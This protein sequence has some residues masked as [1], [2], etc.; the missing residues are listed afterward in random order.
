MN[1]SKMNWLDCLWWQKL[2]SHW[3]K[4]EHGHIKK[5]DES[6]IVKKPSPITSLFTFNVNQPKV[7]FII[8]VRGQKDFVLIFDHMEDT[9]HKWVRDLILDWN[10]KEFVSDSWRPCCVLL[11]NKIHFFET[12][13]PCYMVPSSCIICFGPTIF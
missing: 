3:S 1:F 5:N 10:V 12:T 13:K 6:H 9:L 7:S 4:I 11:F 8:H 2:E